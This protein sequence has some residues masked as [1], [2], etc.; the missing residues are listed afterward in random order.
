VNPT[1]A[2]DL[3]DLSGRLARVVVKRQERRLHGL[4]ALRDVS[5]PVALGALPL[6]GR[7]QGPVRARVNAG[8]VARE[9]APTSAP[10]ADERSRRDLDVRAVGRITVVPLP[11]DSSGVLLGRLRRVGVAGPPSLLDGRVLL[12]LADLFEA[13]LLVDADVVVR[14]VVAKTWPWPTAWSSTRSPGRMAG[15]VLRLLGP[16]IISSG[17]SG[18]RRNS[19]TQS[20]RMGR[21]LSPNDLSQ[22]LAIARTLHGQAAPTEL[23][24]DGSSRR[25]TR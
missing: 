13:D 1:L 20:F 15:L 5:G 12:S 22:I 11:P 10:R 21:L 23:L 2:E 25:K 19:F 18:S 14:D 9:L 4:R 24:G 6:L 7:A 16:V 3:D 17:L 8:S